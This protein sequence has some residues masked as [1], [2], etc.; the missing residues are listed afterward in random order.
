MLTSKQRAHLMGLANKLPT[1]VQIGKFGV[2]EG[3]VAQIDDA[4]ERRE[5]VKIGV[6]KACPQSAKDLLASLAA[7]M[8]AEP[9]HAIG[10]KIILYRRS[11]TP[12]VEHISLEDTPRTAARPPKATPAAPKA[13]PARVGARR[14]QKPT[15]TPTYA[16]PKRG[17]HKGKGSKKK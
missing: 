15:R 7:A 8:Q 6:L 16:A 4:L 10:T 14:D 13:K 12:G 11:S 5:L 2:T 3:V 9:V 1:L 17:P